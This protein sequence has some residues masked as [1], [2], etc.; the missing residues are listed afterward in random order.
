MRSR[1]TFIFRL[2]H[3]QTLIMTMKLLL[4]NTKTFS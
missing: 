3:K 1:L 4:D 2:N